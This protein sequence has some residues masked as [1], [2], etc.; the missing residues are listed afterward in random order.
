[1]ND[2]GTVVTALVFV[3]LGPF[4]TLL[5]LRRDDLPTVLTSG[6]AAAGEVHS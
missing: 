2:S 4:I 3:Y 6:V 1:M 5:A